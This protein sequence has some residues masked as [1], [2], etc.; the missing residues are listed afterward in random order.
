M[1]K[2]GVE[3][4]TCTQTVHSQIVYEYLLYQ[5]ISTQYPGFQILGRSL[6]IIIMYN[7]TTDYVSSTN[8]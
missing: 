1:V 3:L 5:I 2:S 8:N 7:S 6:Y 4:G